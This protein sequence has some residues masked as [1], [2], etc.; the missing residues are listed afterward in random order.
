MMKGIKGWREEL[1]RMKEE[2]KER[3]EEQ[4]RM[5]RGE[6]EKIRKEFKEKE[7]R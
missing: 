7:R 6:L 2:M 1:D 4:G 5:V 3:I